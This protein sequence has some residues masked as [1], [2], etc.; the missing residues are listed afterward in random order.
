MTINLDSPT[1]KPSN[2]PCSSPDFTI[3][4]SHLGLHS[5]WVPLTTFNSDHLPIIID[6]DG[7]FADLLSSGSS[8][9]TNYGKS[10]WTSYTEETEVAFSNLHPPTS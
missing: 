3:T 8:R 1:R 6:P 10:N 2:G 7:W 9:Y 4:N 5:S